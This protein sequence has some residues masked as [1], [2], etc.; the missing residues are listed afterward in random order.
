MNDSTDLTT[1]LTNDDTIAAWN[2]VLFDKFLA[3]R[4]SFVA[5]LAPFGRSALELYPPPAEARVLDIG[6]GFGDT[7]LAIARLIGGRGEAVGVDVAGRFLDVARREARIRGVTNVRYVDVDVQRAPLPGPFDHAFSRFGTMFFAS[8]VA[9]LRNVRRSL[10]AGS[11]LCM[12]VWRKKDE[13]PATYDVE[14]AVLSLVA[15]P[16]TTDEP[17]CG[18]GPFSMAS[19]DVVSA[20][21]LAAGFER[22]TFERLDVS[23]SI[24][25][26]LDHAVA[27]MMDI[28]PAGEVLRLAGPAARTRVHEVIG[29]VRDVLAPYA[30]ADGVYVPAS[31]WIVTATAA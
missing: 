12:V 28:G 11:Q 30:R 19:P 8:P 13:L 15:R 23:M 9:A 1:D 20:Q 3:H 26:D 16:E 22:I 17:T 29:A 5:G 25:R 27:A 24:G 14:Q 18:P 10:R 31:A 21:L 7:T 4:D 2:G 6:C